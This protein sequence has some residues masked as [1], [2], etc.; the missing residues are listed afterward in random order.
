MAISLATIEEFLTLAAP[1]FTVM[2]GLGY[3]AYIVIATAIV[4]SNLCTFF[5][6][7]LKI[8]P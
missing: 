2:Q 8:V 4:G 7:V 3:L 6:A 5:A 1:L